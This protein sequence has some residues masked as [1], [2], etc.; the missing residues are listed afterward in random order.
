MNLIVSSNQRGW[1]GRPLS[2][3]LPCLHPALATNLVARWKL[4]ES[5]A[6]Y[7]DFGSSGRPQSRRSDHNSALG[8][9]QQSRAGRFFSAT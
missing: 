3:R 8:A 6:P 1:L 9:R 4:D 7:A 2:W 5:N